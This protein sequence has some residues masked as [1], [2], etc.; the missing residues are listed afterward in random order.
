[1]L[2]LIKLPKFYWIPKIYKN[3]IKMWLIAACHSVLINPLAKLVSKC[4]KPFVLANVG[5]GKPICIGIK[6][7]C[8]ELHHHF[9][10]LQR[11]NFWIVTGDIMAFY[12]NIHVLNAVAWIHEMTKPTVYKHQ[13]HHKGEDVHEFD[14]MPSVHGN[15][16]SNCLLNNLGS[17][18]WGEAL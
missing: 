14:M 15:L 17:H 11:G 8:N 9:H 6:E 12:L 16:Y 1:M 10:L 3:S 4:L 5:P 7:L 2:S 18:L 13:T